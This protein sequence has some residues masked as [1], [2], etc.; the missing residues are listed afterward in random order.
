MSVNFGSNPSEMCDF[1]SSVNGSI[2]ILWEDQVLQGVEE[3]VMLFGKGGVHKNSSCTG[4]DEDFSVNGFVSLYS[5][6]SNGDR[7]VNRLG[8]H[9]CYKYRGNIKRSIHWDKLLS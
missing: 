9:F 4:I 7:N 5:F 6:A 3:D 1:P 8:A 2:Y